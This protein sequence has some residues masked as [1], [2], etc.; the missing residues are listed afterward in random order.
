MP[1]DLIE[2]IRQ[3]NDINPVSEVVLVTPSYLREFATRAKDG[4]VCPL[5]VKH[6]L[7]IAKELGRQISHKPHVFLVDKNGTQGFLALYSYP[8]Y[9][10]LDWIGQEVDIVLSGYVCVA[11]SPAANRAS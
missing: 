6:A 1:D 10:F 4:S 5:S 3:E 11:G 9:R 8:D 2:I 7:Q